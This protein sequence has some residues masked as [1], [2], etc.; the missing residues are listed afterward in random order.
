MKRL[1]QLVDDL[2]ARRQ[3]HPALVLQEKAYLYTESLDCA[4]LSAR[5]LLALGVEKGDRVS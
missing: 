4:N 3:D 2:A 5:C 1:P